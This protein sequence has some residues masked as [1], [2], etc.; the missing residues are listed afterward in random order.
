MP[1]RT[2]WRRLYDEILGNMQAEQRV[3]KA[4]DHSTNVSNRLASR[5][6]SQSAA[7]LPENI[8]AT[9]HPVFHRQQ[10]ISF[11]RRNAA[12]TRSAS[13]HSSSATPIK[14]PY[15]WNSLTI[16]TANFRAVR[17]AI[18]ISSDVYGVF[19][20]HSRVSFCTSM[21]W[22]RAIDLASLSRS[23]AA[24]DDLAWPLSPTTCMP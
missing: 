4:G 17:S 2:F 20:F 16:N 12:Y 19:R 15:G 5:L 6:G 24:L 10:T 11:S 7:S 8:R 23:I 21:I 14:W 9:A 3:T 22:S 1:S 18:S 13:F